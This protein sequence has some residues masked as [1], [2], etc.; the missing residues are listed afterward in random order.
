MEKVYDVIISGAGPSGS[1]L[2]Y[3]LSKNNI[4]TLILEK[5]RRYSVENSSAFAF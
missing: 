4:N 3:L 2:G 5:C 1:V